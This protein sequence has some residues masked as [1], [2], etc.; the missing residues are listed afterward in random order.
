MAEEMAWTVARARARD[1][2]SASARRSV[3]A[4]GD[5]VGRV[6]GSDLF[7]M[8]DLPPFDT[9]AMDGWAVR[10]Q[11]PWTVVGDCRAGD[12][13]RSL[14]HRECVRIS[15][16]AVAPADSAVL[17][18]ED[19]R[20]RDGVVSGSSAPPVGKD[21]RRRGE[22]VRTGERILREG[23]L[24]TPPALGL[25]AAAGLDT[26]EVVPLPRVAVLILG[27][28]LAHKG[29]PVGGQVRDALS[30]QL[31]AWVEA[32]GAD[33]VSLT[34]VA[35]SL[36]ATQRA[37]DAAEADVVITTGGTARGPADH[38]R[39]AV[40]AASG[41][42]LVDGVAVRPGHPMKLG[43]LTGERALVALPGNPLAAVSGLV[44]LAWPLLDASAGRDPRPPLARPLVV[45]VD[46]SPGAHRLV[47]GQMEGGAVRLTTRRG[48]AMLSGMATAD[49]L[50]VV[51]PG[52]H[53][54][55]GTHVDVLSL[56]W[57]AGL[58]V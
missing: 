54:E 11:G 19:G 45:G 51:P 47:P 42:W 20:E 14:E 8:V 57:G 6:L 34:W 43:V 24:L 52:A 10:G 37:L 7:S 39:N 55:A 41:E 35:D 26:V 48:P 29:L 18:S 9:S 46:A 30:P 22:E 23:Q 15:T 25:A 3:A 21:I 36:A 44:T 28:E 50:A 27:D 17:R 53:A 4:L 2:G 31:P 56:P 32:M 38:L 16:G 13:P 1:L 12:P 33:L 40:E 58:L 5:A 49:V